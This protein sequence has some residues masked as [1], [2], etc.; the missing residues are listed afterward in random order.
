MDS[1]RQ[2]VQNSGMPRQATPPSPLSIQLLRANQHRIDQDWGNFRMVY[3]FWRVYLTDQPGA[4]ILTG[5]REW[6]LRPGTITLIPAGLPFQPFC[7]RAAMA[8]Y[9]VHF[10][11]P[12]LPAASCR[13][14]FPSP[15]VFTPPHS[16][17]LASLPEAF[18]AGCQEQLASPIPRQ[19]LQGWLHLL[20]AERL[21]AL[22]SDRQEWLARLQ[23]RRHRLTP[24]LSL[25]EQSYATRLTAEKIA[26]VLHL[27]ADHTSRLFREWL[28]MSPMQY[29]EEVR[30]QKACRLLLES[31]ETIESIAEATGYRDR[32]YFS[33][34]FKR[35]FQLGPATFRRR[36]G[37]APG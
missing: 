6:R 7:R 35:R 33:R 37:R 32:Y 29:L 21:R 16:G 36:A 18:R 14:L 9:S 34:V 20:L 22:P 12:A 26:T 17:P 23:N 31:D 11:M 2:F 27:S 1:T 28:G 10:D 3:W 4:G 5:S 15:W 8:L 13:S 25:I 30:M 19:E 24:A